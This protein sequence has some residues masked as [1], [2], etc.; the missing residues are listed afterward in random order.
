MAR[1]YRH[2]RWP[3]LLLL[4]LAASIGCGPVEPT[5]RPGLREHGPLSPTA[6]RFR[7][8]DAPLWLTVTATG[9]DASLWV[10]GRRLDLLPGPTPERLA[11]PAQALVELR[12]AFSSTGGFMLEAQALPDPRPWL[13]LSER[14]LGAAERARKFE[15]AETK[16][17]AE[18]LEAA[19]VEAS[20]LSAPSLEGELHLAAADLYAKLGDPRAEAAYLRSL[21]R[22]EGPARVL[23][24]LGLAAL[25][26]DRGETRRAAEAQERARSLMG[27]EPYLV[28]RVL[29]AEGNAARDRGDNAQALAA[30]E[31]VTRMARAL[32]DP[33]LLADAEAGLGWCHKELGDRAMTL[34]HFEAGLLAAE[35][36]GD[37]RAIGMALHN[38]GIIPSDFDHDHRGA[39]PWFERA[40]VAQ[41]TAGYPGLAY[42]LDA[43]GEMESSLGLAQALARHQEALVLRRQL[44][45]VRGEA[46]TLISLGNAATRL[47]R[48]EEA[49]AP[50]VRSA[51]LLASVGDRTWE[52]YAYE[53]L[54]VAELARGRPEEAYRQAQRALEI[55]ESLRERIASEDRRAYYTAEVHS[56]YDLA[57]AAA[58]TL[59][60]QS[61]ER[62]WLDRAFRVAEQSRSRAL[63]DMMML[64]EPEDPDQ[65]LRLEIRALDQETRKAKA[66]GAPEE[67]LATTEAL[68]LPKLAE[69]E[70]RQ[71]ARGA[72][73]PQRIAPLAT[74]SEAEAL[75]DPGT[76]LV[77]LHLGRRGAFAIAVGT[78]TLGAFALGPSEPIEEAA[79]QL[80][81][82][83]AARNE[84]PAGE[85][86]EARA[87]RIAAA[88]R[89]ALT[90]EAE[91]KQ[92]LLGP[93]RGLLS[94]KSKVVVVP[95]GALHYLPL[96]PLLPGVAVTTLPSLTVLLAQRR[97]SP[98][99]S[100]TTLVVMGD[101]VFDLDD[102]RA[103]DDAQRAA[104]RAAGPIRVQ[105]LPFTR[106]ESEAVASLVP[107]KARR[108][109][110]DF[111][112][113]KDKLG[114][115]L[116]RP[117]YLHLATHGVLDAAHPERSGLWFSRTTADGRAQDGFLSLAEIYELELKA[118]L[119]TLSACETA[120]GAE[121]RGE[122]LI[123]LTRGFLHAGARSVLASV[124]KVNDQ[125]TERLMRAFYLGLFEQKLPPALALARAQEALRSEAR[126]R[127]PYYWAGFVL[128]GEFGAA[129]PRGP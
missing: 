52:A 69:F 31:Q 98:P 82:R 14:L 36:S 61:G 118:E 47:G 119:V 44:K 1:S 67:V 79:R 19:A 129:R 74:L 15:A 116:G 17:A 39:L 99:P 75:L 13:E 122:G 95:D 45:S 26:L 83:Y 115:A 49:I 93:W 46:Q 108:L 112:A 107:A 58:A 34:A 96:A 62:R 24:E 123:G 12:G 86:A 64:I 66:Q 120:L 65:A 88:D 32:G 25:V 87:E 125:A 5:L 85:R 97:S 18:T 28:A 55:S 80:Y 106:R 27:A 76:L 71:K 37:G 60:A 42:S 30:L 77:E 78:S 43:A 92:R 110:L 111:E 94:G 128:Q 68:L 101:P 56:Y 103:T 4:L 10:N 127:A 33:T 51:E 59:A 124:W 23:A 126:Y 81:R 21:D 8:P 35:R 63:L 89:E 53:R 105:R 6:R 113:T 73:D 50:L 48:P 90:L 121:V 104:L 84:Q 70:R 91:L 41:R 11:I 2:H 29:L 102:P 114:P 16:A 54:G 100:G 22:A 20:K 72:A 7:G 40:I 38:R 9:A 109:W 57:V 117:R 3:S